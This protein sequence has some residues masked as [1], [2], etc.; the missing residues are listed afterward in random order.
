MNI[1]G[2]EPVAAP[3]IGRL[4]VYDTPLAAFTGFLKGPIEHKKEPIRMCFRFLLWLP[5][6]F[7][8]DMGVSKIPRL[9]M[10]I[11]KN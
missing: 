1:P 2:N 5:P 3:G 10:T 6:H 8:F 7:I 9:T 11:L 4:T